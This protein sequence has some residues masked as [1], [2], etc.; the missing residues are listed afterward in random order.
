MYSGF[1]IELI[2]YLLCPGDRTPLLLAKQDLVESNGRITTGTLRCPVCRQRYLIVNGI[3]VQ[4]DYDTLDEESAHE[5]RLRNCHAKKRGDKTGNWFNSYAKRA[6]I[7]STMAL[8]RPLR[9]KRVL[10]LGCGTGRFTNLIEKECQSILA[11]DFSVES[12][13]R[14]ADTIQSQHQVGLL[15]ADITRLQLSSLTFDRI[16]STLV[17]NLPTKEHRLAMYKLAAESLSNQGTFVF[18]THHYGLREKRANMPRHGRYTDGGIFRIYFDKNEVVN[19][20]KEYF[21]EYRLQTTKI[22]LPFIKRNP[23]QKIAKCIQKYQFTFDIFS[24]Y[25]EKV[26]FLNEFG[27]LIL[28]EASR[29]KRNRLRLQS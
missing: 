29:P 1:P 26:P 13:F 9:G 28:V 23:I 4:L 8:M 7:R 20:I 21:D 17:S 27:K 12:L 15:L 3:V 22:V 11:I 19:E 6:E 10:E 14:L 24:V 16:L 5:L 25:L 2:S 18:S